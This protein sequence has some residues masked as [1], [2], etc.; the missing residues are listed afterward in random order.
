MHGCVCKDSSTP[1]PLTSPEIIMR[2]LVASEWGMR[3]KEEIVQ[4]EIVRKWKRN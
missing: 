4:I 2:T 3:E 1:A